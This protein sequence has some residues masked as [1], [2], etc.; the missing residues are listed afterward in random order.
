MIII[1]I[2]NSIHSILALIVNF[3]MAIADYQNL[4]CFNSFREFTSFKL[5]IIRHFH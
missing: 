1:N 2:I 4:S 5:I 3:A